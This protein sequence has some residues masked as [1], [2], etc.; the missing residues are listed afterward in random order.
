MNFSRRSTGA[1]WLV[2]RATIGSPASRKGAEILDRT[3]SVGRG[4]AGQVLSRVDRRRRMGMAGVEA[5][6]TLWF[7]TVRDSAKLEELAADNHVNVS[8]QS[9]MKFVS[10]SGTATAVE[11]RGKVAELWRESWKVWFPGGKNDPSLVLLQVHG[12]A[13]EYWDNSGANWIKYLIE[14]GRA[15]LSGTRPQVDDDPKIHGRVDL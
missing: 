6:G 10:I 11:D 8:M 14:A 12:D 1:L 9:K 4:I 13:G 2:R 7:F 15:Y 3:S 5:N